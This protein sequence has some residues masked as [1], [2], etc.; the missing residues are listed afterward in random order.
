MD[1]NNA[2]RL[3]KRMNKTGHITAGIYFA[4]S[5]T[6]LSNKELQQREQM[7]NEQREQ[8]QLEKEQRAKEKDAELKHK[9]EEI[10]TKGTQPAT[11]NVAKLKIM[12]SWFKQPGDSKIPVMKAK[13]LERYA[14]TSGCSENDRTHLADGELAAHDGDENISDEEGGNCNDEVAVGE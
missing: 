5:E 2:K 6:I 12:V 7:N 13:L 14:L 9:V 11:W 8:K 1:G 10:H 3:P 4:S